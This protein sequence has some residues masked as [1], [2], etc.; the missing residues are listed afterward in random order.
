M[1]SEICD[2]GADCEDGSDEEDCFCLPHHFTCADNSCVGRE[3]ICDGQLD[4]AQ[5]TSVH[6]TIKYIFIF[7]LAC[8]LAVA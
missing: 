8:H 7:L 3:L 2:G 1:R 5:G 6:C 4:C